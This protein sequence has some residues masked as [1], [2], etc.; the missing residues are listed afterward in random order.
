MKSF[1]LKWQWVTSA[2][3]VIP[4][5]WRSFDFG[6]RVHSPSQKAHK[7]LPGSFLWHVF[8][9]HFCDTFNPLT[10]PSFRVKVIFRPKVLVGIAYAKISR[11]NFFSW[12]ED[13][14]SSSHGSFSPQK[15]WWMLH[16]TVFTIH[17]IAL[18]HFCITFWKPLH[19]LART[20][21]LLSLYHNRKAMLCAI[22]NCLSRQKGIKSLVLTLNPKI[23]KSFLMLK[24]WI[25]EPTE[26]YLSG[27]ISHPRGSFEE[28]VGFFESS[29]HHCTPMR[30]E[31]GISKN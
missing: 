30:V 27:D 13:E 11:E 31:D 9:N 5:R 12:T 10:P 3:L 29:V 17:W 18:C 14:S 22:W 6:S 25:L 16:M 4:D 1:L 2:D 28:K 23:S 21:W 19:W 26:R 8:D 24:R 20:S 15:T 7:N